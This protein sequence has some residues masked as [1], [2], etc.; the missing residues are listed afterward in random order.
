MNLFARLLVL[1]FLPAVHA[2]KYGLHPTDYAVTNTASF[3]LKTENC[4][5]SFGKEA[6][7]VDMMQVPH[8]FAE[9]E[10]DEAL[11]GVFFKN[12]KALFYVAYDGSHTPPS[13]PTDGQY[14]YAIQMASSVTEDATLISYGKA[15]MESTKNQAQILCGVPG[16][17]Y[18]NA[19]PKAYASPESLVGNNK[20]RFGLGRLGL[21]LG[22]VALTLFVRHQMIG[23]GMGPVPASSNMNTRPRP[24]VHTRSP[25]IDAYYSVLDQKAGGNNPFDD[26]LPGQELTACLTEGCEL[27]YNPATQGLV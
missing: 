11:A 23:S 7:V 27:S 8:D 17:D 25:L 21:L 15:R 20:K 18:G 13:S 22:I 24:R 4:Q 2:A 10:F 5:S 1:L 14:H 19:S 3:Q 26:P 6:F 12:P 16:N 9:T